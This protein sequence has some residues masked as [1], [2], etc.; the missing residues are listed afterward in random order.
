MTSLESQ[1]EIERE[2][3]LRLEAQL[4]NL[5]DHDPVTDLLNHRS[6]EHELEEHLAGCERY[7]PEGA[8]L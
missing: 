5:A 1:L 3:T 6:L 7:G 2:R 8:L 4:R